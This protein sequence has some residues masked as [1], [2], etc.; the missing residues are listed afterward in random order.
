MTEDISRY[1]GIKHYFGESSFEKCDCIGLVRLFYREHDW[2]QT[3]TDDNPEAV[4][5]ENF[6]EPRMWARLYRYMLKEF[7]RV[8]YDNLSFGDV[9]VMK[10]ENDEHLGIYVG[11]G[12]VLGMQVPTVYG[13]SESTIYPREWWTPAFRYGFRRVKR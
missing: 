9:I 1:V 10:F 3:F 5:E 11:Y 12:K 8:D 6:A 2:P 7:R 13:K 4:T